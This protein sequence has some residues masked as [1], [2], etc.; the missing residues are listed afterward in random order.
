VEF[1][2]ATLGLDEDICLV[3]KNVI[4]E[5]A[6][7]KLNGI[8]QTDKCKETDC[9][10]KNSYDKNLDKDIPKEVTLAYS[11]SNKNFV[12]AF[13]TFF[14]NSGSSTGCSVDS[15]AIYEDDCLTSNDNGLVYIEGDNLKVK[16]DQERAYKSSVCIIC[17]GEQQEIQ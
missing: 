2:P 17:K 14:T 15:C 3:C 7:V 10:C 11:D 9:H 4:D 1:T 5:S 8:T 6:T 13:D 12:N 16:L